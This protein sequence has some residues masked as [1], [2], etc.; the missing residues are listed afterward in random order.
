M[1]IGSLLM[2]KIPRYRLGKTEEDFIASVYY[3]YSNDII[4]Q[5]AEILKFPNDATYYREQAQR[6]KEAIVK[7]YITA[8]GRFSN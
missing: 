8:N 4:A 3:Y 5:T 2:E 6:I 7:E 1:A